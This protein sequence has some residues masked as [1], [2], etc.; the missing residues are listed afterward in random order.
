MHSFRNLIRT[1]R[2]SDNRSNM[3]SSSF[4][5]ISSSEAPEINLNRSSRSQDASKKFY[6]SDGEVNISHQRAKNFGLI[7]KN[8]NCGKV[9][10]PISKGISPQIFQSSKNTIVLSLT[11]VKIELYKGG[12]FQET[13]ESSTENDG[14]YTW[15]VNPALAD[16]SDYKVRVSSVSEPGIYDE[17]D[18]FT[19]EAKSMTVTEPTSSTIWTKGYSANITWTSTGTISDVQIDLYK[20]GTFRETIESSTEND[21]TY[22]WTVN[23]ALADGSDY[24]VRISWTSDSGIYDE[25]EEFT[26]EAKS[27]TVT[28][29]TSVTIWTKG[30]SANI[31]WTSTG[32]IS[33]VKIELYRGGGFIETIVSSTTDD[34]TYTWT[35]VNP[36]L[37]NAKNYK[38]KI[39]CINV[40]GIYDESDN[41]EIKN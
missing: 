20:G 38:V 37:Q 35:Q 34:G 18:N 8:I 22:T 11:N 14:T 15:T 7:K 30:T 29:P 1:R 13:I 21:G 26:I 10:S 28:E 3:S 36:S 32:T 27:I 4:K 24:K 5:E 25:S 39:I 19:I 31:T 2:E 17:S 9:N 6:S 33:D 12:I 41:F 40:P 23:P 16:G